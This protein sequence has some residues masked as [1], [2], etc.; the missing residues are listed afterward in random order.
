MTSHYRVQRRVLLS[1]S[2]VPAVTAWLGC[3]EPGQAPVDL[4]SD[5]GAAIPG[6]I[7]SNPVPAGTLGSGSSSTSPNNREDDVAYIS[8]S[9]GA[10]PGVLSVRIRNVTTNAPPTEPVP[11]IDG[12]FD[13]VAVAARAGDRLALIISPETGPVTVSYLLVPVRRP[14][15]IVRTAPPKGRTDV[16]L[17]ARP[18]I[19]FSE[20]IDARTLSNA[21]VQLLVVGVAVLGTVAPVPG[22]AL[23]A[24]FTPA[25]PLAQNTTYELL[26]TTGVRDLQG[27]AL[28]ASE[29]IPFTTQVGVALPPVAYLTLWRQGAAR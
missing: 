19:V 18:R 11:V 10:L 16:A 2:L 24:E 1:L 13:P 7:V 6:L 17:N 12:G 20:P 22:D 29:R 8:M 27:D 28:E 9:P 23:L 15:R 26:I 4:A 25:A 3:A 21:T 5:S 14:P